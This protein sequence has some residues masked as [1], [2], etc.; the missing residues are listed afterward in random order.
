MSK[1]RDY[2][3]YTVEKGVLQFVEPTPA[4][5]ITALDLSF[6][7]DE[8]QEFSRLIE[9]VWR[10]IME[11][12]LPDTDTYDQSYKGMLEFEQTLLAEY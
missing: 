1:A 9:V 11:L 3:D 8:L 10:H 12:N 5:D 4:G 7:N 2:R 6:S